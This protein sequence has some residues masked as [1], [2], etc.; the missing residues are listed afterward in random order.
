MSNKRIILWTIIICLSLIIGMSYYK[1]NKERHDATYKVI[2]KRIIESAN[3][4]FKDNLCQ[5]NMTLGELISK[6]YLEQIVDPDTKQY[7]SSS[8]TI[9]F[10]GKQF[11]FT[12]S[13]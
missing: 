6:G 5:K 1:I 8:S 11:V 2:N 13:Y 10:D 7:Y 3:L 4:C 9:S 12:P